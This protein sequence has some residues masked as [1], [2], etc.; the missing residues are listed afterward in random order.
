MKSRSIEPLNDDFVSI[1]DLRN[2]NKNRTQSNYFKDEQKK[3]RPIYQQYRRETQTSRWEKL[4]SYLM[5]LTEDLIF[6]PF[7]EDDDY[8]EPN[9]ANRNLMLA[10]A[11]IDGPQY[12]C[13]QIAKV[14]ESLKMSSVLNTIL[15]HLEQFLKNIQIGLILDAETLEFNQRACNDHISKELIE[16]KKI[17][18]VSKTKSF[19]QKNTSKH[20]WVSLYQN[21]KNLIPLYGK[22]PQ[23]IDSEIRSETSQFKNENNQIE[24]DP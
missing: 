2:R 7:E 4:K 18:L 11:S 24:N 20:H 6:E 3:E 5:N 13:I 23:I 21:L 16:E 22:K 19:I 9:I 12:S 15:G 10:T 8:S 14:N 17:T 1:H